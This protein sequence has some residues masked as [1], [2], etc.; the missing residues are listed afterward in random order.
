[1]S[2]KGCRW[3]FMK[4]KLLSWNVRRLNEGYKHLRD[5]IFD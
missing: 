5:Q 3:L 2:G 4:P 1:L